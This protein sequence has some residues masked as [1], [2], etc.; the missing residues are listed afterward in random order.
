[1]TWSRQWRQRG[2]ANLL[3]NLR[4][5]T[6]QEALRLAARICGEDERREGRARLRLAAEATKSYSV[7]Q[8][9]RSCAD[10]STDACA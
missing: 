4:S 6:P 3:V 7:A 10:A 9:Y 8:V 5:L 2:G 1:M